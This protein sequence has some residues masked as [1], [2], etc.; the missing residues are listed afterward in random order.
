V[1]KYKAVGEDHDGIET[2]WSGMLVKTFCSEYSLYTQHY[3]SNNGVNLT[4]RGDSRFSYQRQTPEEKAA[5]SKLD[6]DIYMHAYI[7]SS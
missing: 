1:Y 5:S 4:Q 7:H 2:N 6:D 3:Y